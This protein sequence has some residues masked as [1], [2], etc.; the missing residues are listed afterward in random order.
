M[1]SRKKIYFWFIIFGV[2]SIFFFAFVIP[3]FLKEIRKNS[4]DLI[5]SKSELASL[6]EDTKNFSQLE[7][8][9]QNY[10]SNLT[11]ISGFFID[12]EVP[13][14]FITFLE[15]NAV[16]FQQKIEI[17]LAPKIKTDTEPWP[18][19]SFQISTHGSFPNSLKF[20]EKLENGP[21][22]IEISDLN[23][24]KLTEGEI[25]ST[26][27]QGLSSGDVE[28]TFSIKVYTR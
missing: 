4:E 1:S 14:E 22:L 11:K 24:K 13:I 5:S 27:F 8:V 18:S 23:I 12:P 15:K 25:Q 26:K 16:F 7:K 9:Y 17:S 10:Q 19:L 6:R 2:I 20:L 3:K 21:Y 28:S